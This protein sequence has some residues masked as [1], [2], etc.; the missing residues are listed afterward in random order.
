MSN[1]DTIRELLIQRHPTYP[2]HRID[3]AVD[4]IMTATRIIQDAEK[5]MQTRF[6]KREVEIA[7][8]VSFNTS[9]EESRQTS[10]R[11]KRILGE[12]GSGLIKP[13]IGNMIDPSRWTNYTDRCLGCGVYFRISLSV[14]EITEKE[15]KELRKVKH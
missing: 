9:I 1:R 12:E 13:Q 6:S 3:D 10:E 5:E 4:T 7:I 15:Y 14:M 8:R 2:P 11:L